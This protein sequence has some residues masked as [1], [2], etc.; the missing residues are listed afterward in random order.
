MGDGCDGAACEAARHDEV[1]VIHIR[2]KVDG[3]AVECDPS[4]DP[5]ADGGDLCR[6][7]GLE[8]VLRIDPDAGGVG[9]GVGGDVVVREGGNDRGFEGADV[10]V[11]AESGGVEIDDGVGDELAGAVVG[12]IAASVG[13]VEGD[14]LGFEEGFR[15]EDVGRCVGSSGDGDDGVVLD[16]QDAP[17]LGVGGRA[18]VQNLLV[19]VLL[20]GVGVGVAEVLERDV[21]QGVHDGV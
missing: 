16:H 6:L 4:P 17:E 9:V 18:G 7:I 8:V 15:G 12:D 19:V 11:D 2:I 10:F 3:Q 14:A 5:D 13:L 20:D 21:G 1:E